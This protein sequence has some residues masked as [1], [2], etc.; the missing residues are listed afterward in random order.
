M[1]RFDREMVSADTA[2]GLHHVLTKPLT[3]TTD[4]NETVTAPIG[5]WTDGASVPRFLWRIY[6]PFGEYFRAAVVHDF[7]YYR[8]E[9]VRSKCDGIFKEAVRACGCS[10]V[11]EWALYTG[12]RIGG[13]YAYGKYRKKE[14]PKCKRCA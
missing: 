7:M 12:V 13:W 8:G 6:P 2:D 5:F 11:T 10:R 3:Y 14:N 9:F 4:Q 1:G